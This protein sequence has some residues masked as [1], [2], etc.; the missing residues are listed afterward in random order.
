M[1]APSS[2]ITLASGAVG[3]ALG[4]ATRLPALE[5]AREIL[6]ACVVPL[7][8]LFLRALFGLVLP[9]VVA[10]LVLGVSELSP[11]HLGRLGRRLFGYTV[12]VS[13]VAVILG[14]GLVNLFAPGANLDPSSLPRSAE[15]AFPAA[16]PAIEVL[17]AMV[18]DNVVRAAADGDMLAVIVFSLFFGAALSVT[19]TD[20]TKF[21]RRG[22]EGLLDVVTKLVEWALHLLPLA[23][24]SFLFQLGATLGGAFFLALLRYVFVVLLALGIHQFGVYSISLRYFSRKSPRAFFAEVRPA[25]LVAFSTASSSAS[26]PSALRVAEENLKLPPAVARFVLTAGSAMNQNGTALFEGVTVLFLAQ[27]YGVDLSLSAQLTVVLV[28]I[29][30]GIG[31]AGVPAGSLPV[32]AMILRMNGIPAEGLGLILGVDR[33]LDM[34]RTTLNVTGDLAAAVYVASREDFP[35]AV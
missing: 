25:M 9:L 14:V 31:T 6:L 33:L 10:S 24:F 13:A 4:L 29:L 23:V 30:G 20:G 16:R 1:A 21:R 26:L 27:A 2:K 8:R 28:S 32:I 18:P 12:V 22:L 15:P 11:R 17:L 5:P 7:G 19:E 3:L 34:C 35:T